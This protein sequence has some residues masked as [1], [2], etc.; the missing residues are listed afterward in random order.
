VRMTFAR[1]VT[2]SACVTIGLASGCGRGA[3]T[4]GIVVD[5]GGHPDGSSDRNLVDAPRGDAPDQGGAPDLTDGAV[6]SCA[7]TL[8]PTSNEICPAMA[9]FAG[10]PCARPGIRAG[11]RWFAAVM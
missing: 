6:D 4:K 3:G 8:F 9:A 1:W 10:A 7:V 5:S 2:V 11:R